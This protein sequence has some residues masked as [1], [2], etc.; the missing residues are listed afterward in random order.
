VVR[1]GALAIETD[2]STVTVPIRLTVGRL[3][4]GSDIM[5]VLK[6]VKIN[7]IET[8]RVLVAYEWTKYL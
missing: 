2:D 6:F 3:V 4:V 1:D 7:A 5:T 8:K